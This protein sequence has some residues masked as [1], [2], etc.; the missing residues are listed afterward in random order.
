[1]G[2]GPALRAAATQTTTMRL[3]TNSGRLAVRVA[4]PAGSAAGTGEVEIPRGDLA[5]ILYAAA[6]DGAEFLFDDTIVDLRQ[7]EHGVDVTFDRAAPRRFDLII[8]ADGLHS[9]VRRLVFGP[10]RDFLRHA[11]LHVATMP[12]EEPAGDPREVLLYNVPGRLVSIHP[13][14][15]QAL[16]A[17]IFR[18]AASPDFDHRDIQAHRRMVTEAYAGVGWRVPQLLERL[19]ESEDLYLDSVSQ[20]RVPTWS[21][22]RIALLGDAA[23]C[24]SLLGD[25]SS[26]AMAGAYTLAAELAASPADH[27]AA[28]RRYESAHRALVEPKQRSLNRSAALLVPRT[29]A[30]ITVRNVA[31]RVWPGQRTA[32]ADGQRDT[33]ARRAGVAVGAVHPSETGWSSTIPINNAKGSFVSSSSAS[34]IWLR[35]SPTPLP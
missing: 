32:L 10:E 33:V 7:D 17:F 12:I 25:G 9:K 8:A 28:F 13:S 3:L 35:C 11:G 34:S 1:M 2:L 31:A 30:A 5:A 27:P 18:G 26:L 20:A 29:R 6:R 15:E 19:Q 23:S 24:V 14:R 16:V 22:G 21:N 4:M